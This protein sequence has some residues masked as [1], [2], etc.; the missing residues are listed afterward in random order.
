MTLRFV[1][2]ILS[3]AAEF[4]GGKIPSVNSLPDF[5]VTSAKQVYAVFFFK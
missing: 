4:S 5:V 2:F 1:D 3:G